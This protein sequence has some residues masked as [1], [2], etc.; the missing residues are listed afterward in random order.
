MKNRSARCNFLIKRIKRGDEKALECLFNEFGPFFLSV[1]KYYLADK[2]FAEDILSEVFVE[3]VRTEAQT[4]D[5]NKN[6]LNLIWTM[7]KRKAF[8]HNG[9]TAREDV[10][11]EIDERQSLALC[12]S[13][14]TV[15]KI[16]VRN[17]IEK[18]SDEENK[19]LYLKF[20]QGLTVR[21]IAKKMDKSKSNVQYI[22][23]GAIKKLKVLLK[24]EETK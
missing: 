6:G 3:L 2:D 18:L 9:K 5:E 17:A 14:D 20:W 10:V 8:R 21:E 19:I 13:D 22:V 1:A 7:I 12:I 24:D 11:E 15:D 23:D 4:F 16:A